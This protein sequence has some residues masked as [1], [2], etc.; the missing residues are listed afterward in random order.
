[1]PMPF[2][3]VVLHPGAH[4]GSGIEAGIARIAAALN[5]IHAATPD[6]RG[7]D[8]PAR[9]DGRA[10]QLP[11]AARLANCAKSSTRWRTRRRVGICTDTCH[12][13]AAGYDLRTPA[14][15]DAMLDELDRELGLAALKCWHFNDSKGSAGQPPRPPHPHWRR[16]NRRERLPPDPQRSTLGWHSPCCW[17]P[18]RGRPQRRF[19]ESAPPLCVGGRPRAHSSRPGDEEMEMKNKRVWERSAYQ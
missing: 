3:I 14:G 9:I 16:R 10:G 8:H 2:P 18:Q 17:K 13:F 7:H 6:V 11:S 19:D 12:A 1:M 4:T 15:Y 5:R